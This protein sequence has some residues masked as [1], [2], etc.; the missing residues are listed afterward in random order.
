MSKFS[1]HSRL[2]RDEEQ[3][4]LLDFF[5]SLATLRGFREAAQV[6]QDLLSRAELT[7][8]A[9]RLKIAKLLLDNITYQEIS[10]QLKVS[11]QTIARVNIWLQESGD[12]FRLMFDRTKNKLSAHKKVAAGRWS[13]IKRRYPIYFWPELLVRE[14]MGI[15]NKRQKQRLRNVITNLNLKDKRYRELQ[16]MINYKY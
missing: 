4:L 7:M 8:L 14:I 11:T 9:K 5:Q 16:K 12:G 1:K 2:A 6:F 15:A 10:R 13:A 3:G